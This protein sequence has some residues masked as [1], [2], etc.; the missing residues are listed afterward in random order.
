MNPSSDTLIVLLH[1]IY[2]LNDH[3]NYYKG[4]L[5][6]EGYDVLTPNMLNREPFAYAEDQE[7]FM[8]FR[9]TIGM[10][11][12]ALQ[13]ESS[14]E[15]YRSRYHRIFMIGFSVGATIAWLSSGLRVDGMIGF[16]GS[17]IRD[18]TNITPSCDTL[19]VFASHETSFDVTALQHILNTHPKTQVHVVEGEHGFMNPFHANYREEEAKRCTEMM[20]RFLRSHQDESGYMDE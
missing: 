1:E 18:Y 5:L 8:Y 9:N 13:I 6:S 19:L 17:R 11:D 3:I 14:I 2:G 20:L 16:Y 10:E 12:A 15:P 7:A 4:I